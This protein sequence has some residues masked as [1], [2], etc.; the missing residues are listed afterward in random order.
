MA[1]LMSNNDDGFIWKVVAGGSWA[2][3]REATAGDGMT[4]GDDNGATSHVIYSTGRGGAFY[5]CA[6]SFFWFDTSGI[7]GTVASVNFELY[8]RA[9]ASASSGRCIIVKSNAFGGDGTASLTTSDFD[10]IV[11]WDHDEN[12]D[13]AGVVDYSTVYDISSSG[14]TTSGYNSLTGTNQLKED[15][16][17]NNVVIICMMSYDYDH[18]YIAPSSAINQHTYSWY[19]EKTGQ[20][21]DPRLNY[22][23]STGYGNTV[24]GVA[25]PSIGTV[26]GMAKANI[27]KVIGV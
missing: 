22:T 27:S 25:P 26:K 19:T 13:D 17:N 7:T 24:K 8:G 2:N 10:A 11:N 6:R 18:K 15:M 16:K 23:L 9:V 5:V 4:A 1:L 21:Q 14:W 3:V 20:T 12:A